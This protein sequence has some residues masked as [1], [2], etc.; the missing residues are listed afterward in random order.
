MPITNRPK[1]TEE[2]K[3]WIR[4]N[5]SKF[6][7]KEIAAW[8]QAPET[9]IRSYLRDNNLEYKKHDDNFQHPISTYFNWSLY[10]NDV[11]GIGVKY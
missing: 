4:N 11:T 5:S 9:V 8:M 2:N 1:L 3:T 10:N 6:T 7:A